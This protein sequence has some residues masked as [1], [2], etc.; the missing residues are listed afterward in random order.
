M[1]RRKII[2][3]LLCVLSLFS[4][5]TLSVAAEEELVGEDAVTEDWKNLT[6][7]LPPEIAD[8]LPES[9]FEEDMI[10]VGESVRETGALRTI[11][12]VIGSLSG[13]KIGECLALLALLVGILLLSALLRA[14][15]SE[16]ES[17]QRRAVSLCCTLALTVLILGQGG[18]RFTEI[19]RFFTLMRTLALSLLPLMG[20][21]YAVGGNVGAAVANHGVMSGFLTILESVCSTT[22]LPIATILVAMALVD[23]V[24]D[25]AT[26][27]A[28]ATLIKRT[29]T[30]GLSFLMMLLCFVLG[31]Q[32]TLAKGADTLALRTARFAAGSF[33]PI[34]GSSVGEALRTVAGSV[35][36]LRGTVGVGGI[37]I[38]FFAFL[39]TFLS[40]LFT[41]ITLQLGGAVAG[42]LSCKREEK[43]LGELAGIWGYFLAVIA[44]L[45]VMMVFSLTLL[46]RCAAAG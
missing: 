46:A 3:L 11:L 38:L 19:S 9:F 37:L 35:Q 33:L 31:L 5:L 41:R 15:M 42:L 44:A 32:T 20:T 27:S 25:R 23:A 43:L 7:S 24:S 30:L 13:A 18:T 28:L 39:P 36:Y 16:R 21:L 29:F 1:R 4:L 6:G 14:L 45:F 40:V 8:L 10:A 34:V 17:G 12:Q 26:L 22:V 2:S